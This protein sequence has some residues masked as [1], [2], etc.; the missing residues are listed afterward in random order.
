VLE[1]NPL[2]F[3]AV[4]ENNLDVALKIYLVSTSNFKKREQYI[5][6]DPRFSKLKKGTKNMVYL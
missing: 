5:L 1:K 2:F 6:G 4:D 3:G